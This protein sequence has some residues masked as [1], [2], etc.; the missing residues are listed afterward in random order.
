MAALLLHSG[1]WTDANTMIGGEVTSEISQVWRHPCKFRNWVR[2]ER[3][4]YIRK[5]KENSQKTPLLQGLTETALNL[6]NVKGS[7]TSLDDVNFTLDQ[8]AEE[9]DD[10]PMDE[11]KEDFSENVS[12]FMARDRPYIRSPRRRGSE[13][14]V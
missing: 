6:S 14:Y 11:S 2:Q 12:N 4:S 9:K 10:V 7:G 8:H 5:E 13:R 1:L 3:Q